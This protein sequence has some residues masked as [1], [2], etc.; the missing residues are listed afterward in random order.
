MTGNAPGEWEDMATLSATTSTGRGGGTISPSG[1]MA[2]RTCRVVA[3][4][5]SPITSTGPSLPSE[6]GPFPDLQSASFQK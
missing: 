6:R 2:G 5:T 3:T 1:T 4:S